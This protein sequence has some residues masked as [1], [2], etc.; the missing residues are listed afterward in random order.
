[1]NKDQHQ[2]LGGLAYKWTFRSLCRK[3]KRKWDPRNQTAGVCEC[4]SAEKKRTAWLILLFVLRE[5]SLLVNVFSSFWLFKL[6]KSFLWLEKTLG[7]PQRG[8]KMALF[9]VPFYRV[10]FVSTDNTSGEGE[11][12]RN[13]VEN[14]RV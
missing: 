13:R 2:S 3:A 7:G 10:C 1:M 12:G 5:F 8:K 9:L 14:N 6:A 4:P 11:V